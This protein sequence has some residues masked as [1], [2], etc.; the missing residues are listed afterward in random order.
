[1]RLGKQAYSCMNFLNRVVWLNR[2]GSCSTPLR[3]SCLLIF[4]FITLKYFTLSKNSMKWWI[5]LSLIWT[6]EFWYVY[7]YVD[8]GWKKLAGKKVY[9]NEVFRKC[10]HSL[11]RLLPTYIITLVN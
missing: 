8:S 6:E 10:H 7:A 3:V 9:Q 5:N 11:P 2:P 4:I 1:M